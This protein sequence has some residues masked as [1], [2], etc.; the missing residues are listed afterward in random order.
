MLVDLRFSVGENLETS[1]LDSDYE[2]NKLDEAQDALC[3]ELLTA[4][5][6]ILASYFDHTLDGSMRYYI[7][8]SIPYDYE[9]ILMVTNISDDSTLPSKTVSTAWHDRLNIVDDTML[10][11]RISWSIIDNYIEFPN[12]EADGTLRIWYT[13]RP[14]GFFYGLVGAGS[15]TTTV[16][17][18]ATPVAGEIIP[19]DDY[20]IGMK[21]YVNGQVRRI[22]DYVNSTVTATITPAWTT[23][24]VE[25]TDTVELIS[26]LPEQYQKIIVSRAAQSIRL[27]QDDDDSGIARKIDQDENRAKSRLVK[28]Q[29]QTPETIRHIEWL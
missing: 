19:K 11:D 21:V 29:K 9:T 6:L 4:N 20:Y 17:F 22:T 28:R 5:P 12:C 24:P 23:T 10:V 1:G 8:D 2:I 14:T 7:P 13:R 25:T 18:P 15:T 26:P 16:V 27:D 3:D